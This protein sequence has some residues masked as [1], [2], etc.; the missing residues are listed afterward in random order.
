MLLSGT[1]VNR[2]TMVNSVNYLILIAKNILSFIAGNEVMFVLF[3]GC[4]ITLACV[5]VRKVK[6]TSKV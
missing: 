3:C 5:I 2:F 4:I 6:K 1:A